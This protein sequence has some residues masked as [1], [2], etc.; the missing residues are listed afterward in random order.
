MSPSEF[1]LHGTV[2]LV[3]GGNSGIGLGMADGLARAGADVCVWG[4]NPD[5]NDAAR[6]QL[7]THGGRVL[8][9]VCDVADEAQVVA[10]FAETVRLLGKVDSCFANAGV[11]GGSVLPFYEQPTEVWRRVWAVN[12][13]GAFFTLRAAAKHMVERGEG[14]RLV[15]TASVSAIHGA[16]RGEAYAASKG[17]LVATMRGLAVE[18][19]RYDITANVITPGWIETPMT[20]RNVGDERFESAVIRR[21]PFRRWGTGQDFAG[22]AVYLA[23]SASKYHTGDTFVIDGGYTRF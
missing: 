22:I 21:V 14:G 4:T 10:S 16:P 12:L 17:A 2:A 7:E 20:A 3:T 19:A 9:L 1:D 11:G 15:S 18:L 5:K 13:D 8:A 6:E 23:S